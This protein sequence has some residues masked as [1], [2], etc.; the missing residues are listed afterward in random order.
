MNSYMTNGTVSYLQSLAD[1]HPELEFYLMT[2]QDG[3]MLYYESDEQTIFELGRS[4]QAVI[5]SGKLSHTGYVVINHIPVAEEG[6]AMF[7][8]R[9][10]QRQQQVENTPGFKAFRLLRPL[11]GN[12]YAAFTQWQSKKA[13]EDW[14]NSDDFKKAHSKPSRPPA[15]Q[16]DRPF[17]KK[18][19]MIDH[20]EK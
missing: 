5:E 3:A 15:Y 9:F 13:F 1:N 17:L 18:Y 14:T 10:K 12:T 11:S 8:E 19:I 6:H 20:T 2:D 16:A 4:F 7:E